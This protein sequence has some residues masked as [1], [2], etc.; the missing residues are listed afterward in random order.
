MNA[1]EKEV[2]NKAIARL[3]EMIEA[4]TETVC[5]GRHAARSAALDRRDSCFAIRVALAD[6][7]RSKE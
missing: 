3:D 2:A 5:K 6:L 4:E 7:V 1:Q